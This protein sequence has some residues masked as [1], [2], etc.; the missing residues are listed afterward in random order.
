MKQ[1]I[2]N[3][4][5]NKSESLAK[6]WMDGLAELTI[7]WREVEKIAVEAQMKPLALTLTSVTVQMPTPTTTTMTE[8]L[9]SLE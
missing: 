3:D 4:N 2:T 8:A 1:Q 7:C 5:S 6:W 9:T